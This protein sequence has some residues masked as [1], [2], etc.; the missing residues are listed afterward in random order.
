MTDEEITSYVKSHDWDGCSG[1]KA[2]GLMAG[3]IKNINGSYSGLIGLP[4]FEARQ[5]L[6]KAGVEDL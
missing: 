3:F 6:L 5:L 2:E 1:Y 4:Q